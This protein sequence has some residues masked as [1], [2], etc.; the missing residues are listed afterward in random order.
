MEDFSLSPV[1]L[2]IQAG[3]VG[4]SVMAI[5]LVASVWCW[6]LI[7]EALFGV[8]R[9]SRALRDAQ[10][11]VE[12]PLL[13]AV[14]AA[15]AQEA[16]IRVSGETVTERR[17]RVAEKITRASVESADEGGGRA[18]Q[19]RGRFPLSRLSSACSARSGGSWRVSSA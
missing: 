10:A 12:A 3:L 14:D 1:S 18:R 7:I 5:L 19:S 6:L 4:K 11:G 2:F 13:A 17:Q 16:R 9:L 15:G 8:L